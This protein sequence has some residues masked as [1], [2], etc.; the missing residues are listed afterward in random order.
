MDVVLVAGVIALNVMHLVGFNLH[1]MI[2]LHFVHIIDLNY[3]VQID[4]LSITK[5]DAIDCVVL[6]RGSK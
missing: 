2:H 5:S 1:T 4:S 6:Y 3:D